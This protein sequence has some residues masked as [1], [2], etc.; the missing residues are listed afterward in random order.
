[1]N[2]LPIDLTQGYDYNALLNET[3]DASRPPDVNRSGYEDPRYGQPQ[4][5]NPGLQARLA[6]RFIF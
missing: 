5:W 3:P 1:M 4:Y 6:V 2:T